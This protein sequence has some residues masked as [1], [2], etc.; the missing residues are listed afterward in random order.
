MLAL[1]ATG[2]AVRG[3]DEHGR[4]LVA[5]PVVGGL[6]PLEDVVRARLEQETRENQHRTPGSLSEA[7]RGYLVEHGYA[8]AGPFLTHGDGRQLRLIEAL[9]ARRQVEQRSARAA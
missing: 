8:A 7:L 3:V 5:L 4:A 9:A 2:L 1:A 6:A